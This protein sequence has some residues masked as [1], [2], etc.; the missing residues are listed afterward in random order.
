MQDALA[1]MVGSFLV[2]QDCPLYCR[3]S[4]ILKYHQKPLVTVMIKN[5]PHIFKHCQRVVPILVLKH[6]NDWTIPPFFP[7]A[8]TGDQV[9]TPGMHHTVTLHLQV[10]RLIEH[11]Q[12]HCRPSQTIQRGGV[13]SHANRHRWGGTPALSYWFTNYTLSSVY[14]LLYSVWFSNPL[15]TMFVFLPHL[16][17]PGFIRFLEML[18]PLNSCGKMQN[19]RGL[20]N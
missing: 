16:Y 10:Q 15:S 17:Y 7:V 6:Q 19:Q 13:G 5:A 1:F 18:K 12:A 4:G 3:A 11:F 20:Y 2:V 14:P 8:N 9:P